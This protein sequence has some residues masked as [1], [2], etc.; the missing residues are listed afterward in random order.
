M[1]MDSPNSFLGFCKNHLTFALCVGLIHLFATVS[2]QPFDIIPQEPATAGENLSLPILGG[3]VVPCPGRVV[4]PP[5]NAADIKIDAS[6]NFYK[7]CGPSFPQGFLYLTVYDLDSLGIAGGFTLE[8]VEFLTGEIDN[9]SGN[10]SVS[11]FI[12]GTN[13]PPASGPFSSSSL[14]GVI[15]QTT[16]TLANHSNSNTTVHSVPLS[17][18]IPPTS[19]IAVGIMVNNQDQENSF[20]LRAATNAPSTVY[21]FTRCFESTNFLRSTHEFAVGLLTCDPVVLNSS[22]SITAIQ[23]V[24]SPWDENQLL[25]FIVSFSDANP[26]DTFSFRGDMGNGD[27]VTFPNVTSPFQFNYRYLDDNPT[28]TPQD[29]VDLRNAFTI[30][31]SAGYSDTSG[32]F[33]TSTVRNVRPVA[34][35][36][37]PYAALSGQTVNL[38]GSFT[39]VGTLDTH[40][41]VWDLD[42]DGIYGES[43]PPASRGAEN[44]LTPTLNTTGLPFGAYTVSLRVTDD[45][46]GVGFSEQNVLSPN[47]S[48]VYIVSSLTPVPSLSTI[49]SGREQGPASVTVTFTEPVTQFFPQDVTFTRTSP[50]TG[51]FAGPIT[52]IQGADASIYTIGGLNNIQNQSPGTIE[53]WQLRIL[54]ASAGHIRGSFTGNLMLSNPV[55]QVFTVAVDSVPAFVETLAPGGDGNNDGIPDE[56]Q[57]N[58]ASVE[59]DS[60]ASL[61]VVSPDGTVISN[62]VTGAPTLTVPGGVTFPE[63]VLEL[64]VSGG[65]VGGTIPVDLIYSG[66][67]APQLDDFYT[68]D[69]GTYSPISPTPTIVENGGSYTV[70]FILS[71]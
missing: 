12:F 48:T 7:N 21:S 65:P 60:G 58:V 61:T 6:R 71:D 54:P 46:T 31:D 18:T 44:T 10:S 45:D 25:S 9:L 66:S 39:D 53:T 69:A 19:F 64:E 51:T 22:P 27:I 15:A 33:G 57:G 32:L 68:P 49:P 24:A 13:P 67:S 37:G 17:A 55:D 62:L 34:N 40:T 11:V 56:D 52:L 23:S 50:G 47:N 4:N 5:L 43:G 26:G 14:T 16:V 8:G 35:A 3:A 42:N 2:A 36:G 1:I 38:S 41:F 70:Q 28:G 63:G 20:A 29:T 59:L 30:T